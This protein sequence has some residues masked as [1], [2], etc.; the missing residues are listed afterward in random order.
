MTLNRPIKKSKSKLVH[1]LGEVTYKRL[2]VNGKFHK[3]VSEFFLL[4]LLMVK[5]RSETYS[6]SY[7]RE[8]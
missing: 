2:D 8:V 6:N 3:K 4:Q 5:V 7:E 1:F